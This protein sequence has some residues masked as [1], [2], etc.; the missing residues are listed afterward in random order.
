MITISNAPKKIQFLLGIKTQILHHRKELLYQKHA[1][2]H[3]H[4]SQP[5]PCELLHISITLPIK[6]SVKRLL[7]TLRVR[8]KWKYHHKDKTRVHVHLLIFYRNNIRIQNYLERIIQ[9]N[10]KTGPNVYYQGCAYKRKH[11]HEEIDVEIG[12]GDANELETSGQMMQ[13]VGS[14]VHFNHSELV[15]FDLLCA[16]TRQSLKNI[17]ALRHKALIRAACLSPLINWHRKHDIVHYNAY[18]SI[19]EIVETGMTIVRHV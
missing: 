7:T 5:T 14:L 15:V 16:T 2:M 9:G 13:P 8:Y 6:E 11:N 3:L 19:I 18:L 1:H 17:I 4:L 10:K 12:C